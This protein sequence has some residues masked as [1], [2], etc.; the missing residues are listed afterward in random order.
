VV[1]KEPRDGQGC[2]LDLVHPCQGTSAFPNLLKKV[3]YLA[4]GFL[5]TPDRNNPW[6]LPLTDTDG[7]ETGRKK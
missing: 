2:S 7:K 4:S 3:V 5:P 6:R 1:V